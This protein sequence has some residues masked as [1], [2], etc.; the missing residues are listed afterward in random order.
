MGVDM[1]PAEGR[2]VLLRGRSTAFYP[3]YEEGGEVTRVAGKRV[4]YKDE[5]GVEKFTHEYAAIVDT[6]AEAKK[7]L[8]FSHRGRLRVNELRQDLANEDE[9]LRGDI[10]DP[11]RSNGKT[12]RKTRTRASK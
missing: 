11:S 3:W 4:Y 10:I 2:I 5:D 9:S 12:V 6:E 8:D 1:I 7:L